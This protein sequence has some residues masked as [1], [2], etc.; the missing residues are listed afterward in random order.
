MRLADRVAIV[1]GGAR[2]IG[3]AI[4]LGYAREGAHVVVADQDGATAERTAAEVRALGRRG[5]AVAVDVAQRAQV[6]TLVERVVQELG[7]LDVM[8]SNAGISLP[9]DFL[10]TP[11]ELWDRTIGVNLKGVFLCGQAAARQMV[12]QGGGGAIVNTASQRVESGDPRGVPYVASKGGVRSLTKAMALAL[13]P[14]GIRVNAIGPG[15]TLTDL[16]RERMAD[17]ATRA[18][19]VDRV[20]L[21]RLGDPEDMVG[22]AVFL[23][24]DEARF[25]TG[26]TLYVDGGWLA[27]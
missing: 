12:R 11:E 16:N 10:D 24:S 22:A 18:R 17:P 8:V 25:V 9:H 13:A 23:A 27:G 1:T 2:G 3:R 14:Y 15:P 4:A 6:E 7:R 5:L 26:H 19:F 20:P 21:G